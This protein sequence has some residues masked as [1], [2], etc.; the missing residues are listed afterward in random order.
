MEFFRDMPKR[1]RRRGEGSRKGAGGTTR[2]EP[3]ATKSRKKEGDEG[4]RGHLLF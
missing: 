1:G 4:R 2:R 3:E